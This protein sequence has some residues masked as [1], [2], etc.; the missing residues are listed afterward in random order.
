[1]RSNPA[2]FEIFEKLWIVSKMAIQRRTISMSPRRGDRS[3]KKAADQRI[4]RI[5]WTKKKIKAVMNCGRSCLRQ[6]RKRDIPMSINRLIQT[7]LNIQSGGLKDGLFNV[8]Y[9]VGMAGVVKREPIKPANWQRIRLLIS[10]IISLSL[11]LS[12]GFSGRCDQV[13]ELFQNPGGGPPDDMILILIGINDFLSS[14][15]NDLPFTETIF[16]E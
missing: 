3:P 15:S 13:Q 9:Q 8:L 2:A 7:G 16:I 6:T 1:M 4:L 10:L 5:N 11:I 12:L 14:P